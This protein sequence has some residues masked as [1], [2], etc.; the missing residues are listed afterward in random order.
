MTKKAV[1][2]G[3][4]LGGLS[5][6]IRLQHHG[7]QVT[8][9]EKNFHPGGKLHEVH[10]GSAGF[11]FGPNTITMPHVFNDVLKQTGRKPEDYFEFIQLPRHT[12]NSFEDGSSFTFS[13]N[14]EDMKQELFALD[15]ASA[16]KYESYQEEVEKLFR[17]ADKHFLKRTFRSW[18]DFISLPLAKGL[19]SSRPLETMDS[20]HRRFFK[21][22]RII[23]AFNRYATYIG[24]SPFNS[25]A[26]FS[27]I[28]HLEL[29][30]G[31]YYT[32][33]GNFRIAD[34]L[35][36]AAAESG[37]E[38]I[39]GEEVVSLKVQNN[40]ISEAVTNSDK[41][42]AGDVFL[43]NG[44]LLS[45]YPRLVA[46]EHRPSFSD[47]KAASSD[48]SVSAYVLMAA[49]NKR[50]PL[51]HHHVFFSRNPKKE[52]EDIFNKGQY[53]SDP[54]VYICTSS[55]TEPSR[56]PDGDNLFILVNAPPLSNG[57]STHKFS[58]EIVFEKL[59]RFGLDLSSSITDSM[60]VSPAVIEK[61]FNAYRGAL[62]GLSSNKKKNTFLRPFNKAADLNNLY[63]S[64]GSTHPG[65]GSPMVTLSG[66]NV[67][68]LIIKH[69]LN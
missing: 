23:S 61:R 68:E 49:S 18:K 28:G 25:P 51:N 12:T 5:A 59:R 66:Q 38:F 50:H 36:K 65:G 29:S 3:A 27:L 34:G 45:Q 31:V 47:K 26:T 41:T 1:I 60:E 17:L 30:D 52:F 32:K 63:F 42:V 46:S 69:H 53:S 8:V 58:K 16:D 21:D 57:A 14:K 40:T 67:A 11:D 54:T 64:G 13:S 10:L 2:I 15:P 33:G 6:A 44:D 22:E 56:S 35:K 19:L 55:K 37:V 24:S 39:Y 62:Y 48:P 7:F 9:I 4:G 43:L 20:F